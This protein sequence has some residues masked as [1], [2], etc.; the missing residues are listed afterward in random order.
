MARRFA[1]DPADHPG[2]RIGTAM[3]KKNSNGKTGNSAEQPAPAMPSRR[4]FFGTAGRIGAM[5]TLGGLGIPPLGGAAFAQQGQ[6]DF[7]QPANLLPGAQLDSRFAVSFAEPVTEG[8]RLVIEFFTALNRRDLPAIASTLHFPF[9]IYEDIEP[10]VFETEQDFINSPPPTLNTTGRGYTRIGRDS[11]DLLEG[12]YSVSDNDSR[13]SIQLISTIWHELGYEDNEYPD[14]E[15]FERIGS[16][17][18][19]SAFGY[20]DEALLNDRSTGTLD[21][22]F[23]QVTHRDRSNSP[24]VREL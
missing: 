10:L 21:T 11:Y 2:R 22:N 17:G 7:A 24:D 16:Q 19:L 23:G 5:S 18:Y 14:A 15:M 6:Y 13:W 20:R 9:A 4:R 3:K 1:G 12:E 8:L